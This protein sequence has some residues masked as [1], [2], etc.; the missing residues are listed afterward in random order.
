MRFL[1]VKKN[2][3]FV[4]LAR[5]SGERCF[6]NVDMTLSETGLNIDFGEEPIKKSRDRMMSVFPVPGNMCVEFRPPGQGFPK[7]RVERK[8]VRP[9]VGARGLAE[10]DMTTRLA[11]CP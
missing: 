2:F 1:E 11:G 9:C 4:L 6:D 5:H 10:R 8:I 7:K 3:L